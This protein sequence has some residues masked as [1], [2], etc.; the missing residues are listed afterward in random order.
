MRALAPIL[1]VAAACGGGG[2]GGATKPKAPQ[3][4]AVDEKTAEKDAR[5]LATEIYETINRGSKD[6]L[7][8]LLDDS[9]VVFG[10]RRLDALGT[11]AETL[12]ALGAILDPKKKLGLRSSSLEVV[13]STGGRSAWAFDVINIG[14]DPHAVMA[15]LI[16]TDDLW[17]L[18]AAM[19]AQ[20]PAALAMK[21]EAAKDAIVPPGAGAKAKIEPEAKGAVERFQKG[22]LDQESWGADLA[23]RSDAV[24]VGPTFGEVARGKKDIKKLWKQRTEAK[25]REAI[26][27]EIVAETTPDGQ[28]A[29][30]TAPVTRVADGTAPMPLRAFAVFEKTPEG[31]RMIALQESLAIAEPGAGAPFK[32]ILPP[33]PKVEV[34]KPVVVAKDEPAAKKKKKKKKADVA[35]DDKPAKKTKKAKKQ[36]EVADDEV[37]KPAKKKKKKLAEPASDDEGEADRPMKKKKKKKAAVE[38]EASG[39]DTVIIDDDDDKPAKKKKKKKKLADDE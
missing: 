39:S 10:P 24:V 11:R 30:V 25:T 2:G 8:S 26:S 27:G 18:D 4:S 6:S 38:D 35:V 21:S 28:I 33:A 15:I 34:E 31:W 7:F 23:S 9:L 13:A 12:V 36:A 5:G 32:K 37:E 22:L 17:Q 16:N 1:A 14:G 3:Q 29:W 20:M 19:V